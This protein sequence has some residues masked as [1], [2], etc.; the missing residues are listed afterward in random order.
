VELTS[1]QEKIFEKEPD[2]C[3]ASVDMGASTKASDQPGS[4]F[5]PPS[6]QTAAEKKPLKA[7]CGPTASAKCGAKA[8]GGSVAAHDTEDMLESTAIPITTSKSP[9]VGQ[10][11]GIPAAV[12]VDP[13]DAYALVP[14]DME[15]GNA[16]QYQAPNF[17]LVGEPHSQFD[18]STR[19]E[20]EGEDRAV[21]DYELIGREPMI[22]VTSQKSLF[23]LLQKQTEAEAAAQRRLQEVQCCG[24][25]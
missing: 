5:R 1:I 13:A 14:M 20:G 10:C 8:G 3:R 15:G 12:A 16:Y 24:F 9:I 23:E 2:A 7:V 11:K 17:V 25:D 6:I 21:E 22:A 18:V 19:P 4:H